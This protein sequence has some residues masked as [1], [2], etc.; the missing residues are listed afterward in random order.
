MRKSL[1][2]DYGDGSKKVF[3]FDAGNSLSELFHMAQ[4]TKA[5][6]TTEIF[7]DRGEIRILAIQIDGYGH[8]SRNIGTWALTLNGT[9]FWPNLI[10]FE[11]GSLNDSDSIV[12]TFKG[13]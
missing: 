2:I 6:L 1:A 5:G 12:F 10:E 11:D 13:K 8:G 9:E 4:K 7:P 3:S